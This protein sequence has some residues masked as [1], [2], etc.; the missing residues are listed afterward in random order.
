MDLQS[1][2]LPLRKSFHCFGSSSGTKM[3]AV[4]VSQ[5][6][7]TGSSS[8]S[9]LCMAGWKCKKEDEKNGQEQRTSPTEIR[10]RSPISE[11]F[12]CRGPNSRYR[13]KTPQACSAASWVRILRF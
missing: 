3:V 13:C 7:A 11:H 5:W 4:T 10:Y 12:R 8:S 9:S 1:Q 6:Y 2:A